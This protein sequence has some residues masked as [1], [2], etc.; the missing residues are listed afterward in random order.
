MK[1][2][3][4]LAPVPIVLIGFTAGYTVSPGARISAQ[5][6][7]APLPGP[8]P[9]QTGALNRVNGVHQPP[10]F[11]STIPAPLMP[12]RGRTMWPNQPN[13]ATYWSLEDLRKSHQ[14]LA[15]AARAGRAVNPNSTLHHF[16]YW[17]RTHAMFV[18]HAAVNRPPAVAEQ[19]LGY[20]QFIIIM[21]G[22]GFVTAGGQLT[23]ATPLKEEGREIFGE[24]RGAGIS[25]GETFALREGDWVSIP[26]DVPAQFSGDKP[27]GLT[28][29]VMK[30]NAQLYPWDLIR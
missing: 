10:E 25:G 18:N 27:E 23:K 2:M 5:G 9:D 1:T 4:H 6:N 16:P 28:Y 8:S 26:P 12:H 29:M 13:E 17:T 7:A 20:A 15:E 11:K 22:A 24:L 14:T 30:I 3:K 21:G 19:H